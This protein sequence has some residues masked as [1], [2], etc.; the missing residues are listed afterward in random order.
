MI[1]EVAI[2]SRELNTNEIQELYRR[3]ANR[4]KFQ[5]RACT[6]ADCS[7]NPTW[8]GPALV[9]AGTAAPYNY[10]SELQNNTSLTAS[11][12]NPIG[13]VLVGFPDLLFSWFSGFTVPV[14]RY[15]QYR[16]ILESDDTGTGCNYGSGATWCSPELKSVTATP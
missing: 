14:Q 1:D 12:G 3:G 9:K 6:T 8:L 7:D 11:T 10:F 4:I 16:T 15:F 2:W 13:R 5:T